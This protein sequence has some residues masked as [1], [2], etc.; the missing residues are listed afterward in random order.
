MR[1]KDLLKKGIYAFTTAAFVAAMGFAI[2]ADAASIAPAKISVNAGAQTL[3]VSET[4]DTEV[5]VGY[6]TVK[7]QNSKDVLAIKSTDWDVY[8][9]SGG[10]VTVDLSHIKTNKDSYIQVKG[11][12]NDDAVTIKVKAANNSLKLDKPDYSV[13]NPKIKFKSGN[14]EGETYELRSAANDSWTSF[15]SVE[16]TDL[17][18][19]LDRG[20]TLYVRT[21]ASENGALGQSEAKV[22]YPDKASDI[23]SPVYDKVGDNFI[24]FAG[25][26]VKLSVAKRANGPKLAA[27]YA[28]GLLTLPKSTQARI[29]KSAND[30]STNV[31]WQDGT[32]QKNKAEIT[33][34]DDK[35]KFGDTTDNIIEARTKATA[36]KPAS[37]VASLKV[38]AI[39]TLYQRVAGAASTVSGGSIDNAELHEISGG[40]LKVTAKTDSKYTLEKGGKVVFTNS[41]ADN[42]FEIAMVAKDTDPTTLTKF[43]SLKAG[44]NKTANLS[45]KK[46]DVGKYVYIR[47][48]GDKKKATWPTKF[49][50]L[51]T[52]GSNDTP[53]G[54]GSG[55]N[56]ADVT[57]TLST[58]VTA[59]T[60]LGTTKT[61]NFT[62]TGMPDGASAS[63]YEW[64]VSGD[65]DVVV[66]ADKTKTGATMTTT[67]SGAKSVTVKV[68]YAGDSTH[69]SAV[70]N[71]VTISLNLE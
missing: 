49:V 69:K 20:A 55:D 68:T 14:N 59:I 24:Q 28:K 35:I 47:R 57:L 13:D 2:D 65:T 8:D 62:L 39:E 11:N 52:V 54:G 48:A 19:Y 67:A 71:E 17:S 3:T 66:L 56:K 31:A 64:V 61:A 38:P 29:L 7:T 10:S 44:A 26:E 22:V 5:L 53:E 25:K 45:T 32:E 50:Y 4:D 43:T 58:D 1:N 12:K 40:A 15:S 16:T 41:D 42:G 63:D 34:G 37:R 60:R 33:V 36:S 27:D 18:K 6:G 9:V 23:T 70:S 51:G 21:K 30:Y 46:E